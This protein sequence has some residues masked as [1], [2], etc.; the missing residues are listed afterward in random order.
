MLL[1]ILKV[2]LFFFLDRSLRFCEEE[3][4]LLQLVEIKS[5]QLIQGTG[6]RKRIAAK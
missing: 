2:I 4:A 3:Q 1:D 6:S 5:V